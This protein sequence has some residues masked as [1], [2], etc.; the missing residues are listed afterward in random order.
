MSPAWCLVTTHHRPGLHP[1][2][3]ESRQMF[4]PGVGCGQAQDTWTREGTDCAN[5]IVFQQK[6]FFKYIDA[7]RLIDQSNGV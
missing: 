1:G 4:V 3:G 7:I 2:P 5:N 6:N